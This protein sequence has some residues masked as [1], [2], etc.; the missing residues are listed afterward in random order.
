MNLVI[1]FSGKI[2][3]GKST[4]S[5]AV[6][7]ELGWSRVSFGEYVRKLAGERGLNPDSLPT[8]QELGEDLVQNHLND[9]CVGVLGQTPWHAGQSLVIDGLRHVEV[10][11]RL[12]LLVAPSELLIVHIVVDATTRERRLT[13]RTAGRPSGPER[14]LAASCGPGTP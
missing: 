1:A 9:F 7:G 12:R 6:A 5:R 2:A 3:S 13:T 10:A 4:L 8:L 14:R 11:E